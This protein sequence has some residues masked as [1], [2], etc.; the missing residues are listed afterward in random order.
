MWAPSSGRSAVSGCICPWCC[1]CIEGRGEGG[2]RDSQGVGL[3]GPR[4]LAEWGL[5][6]S[7]PG[8]PMHSSRLRR[9]PCS[10]E[11]RHEGGPHQSR[12]TIVSGLRRQR[13]ALL[14]ARA[15]GRSLSPV[16]PSGDRR[17]GIRWGN[18]PELF[19][20]FFLTLRP[21]CS[22]VVPMPAGRFFHNA[23]GTHGTDE[24]VQ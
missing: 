1:G 22:Q 4:Y 16:C 2:R 18:P 13:G 9:G 8:A 14:R 23:G 19:R 15:G 21:V 17:G 6:A 20:W 5:V 12:S 7:R 24:L 11:E 10:A 3:L